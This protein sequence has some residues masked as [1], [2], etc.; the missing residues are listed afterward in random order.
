MISD[1]CQLK[2]SILT[3][4]GSYIH[5][6]YKKLHRHLC[7]CIKAHNT[8]IK[9]FSLPLRFDVCAG[10]YVVFGGQHKLIVE[11]PLG[12][13]VQHSRGVQLDH[14][15]VLHRQIVPCTLQVGHLITP[16]KQI[17]K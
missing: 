4:T 14:L 8:S 12:F 16:Q 11:H 13:V 9:I 15:V 5:Y 2:T 7:I 1:S 3:D 6:I 17:N 10:A